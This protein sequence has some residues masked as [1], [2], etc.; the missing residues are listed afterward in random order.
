MSARREFTITCVR[1]DPDHGFWRA[2]VTNG[3]TLDVDR[4]HG[5]WQSD[6]RDAP[7]SRSFHRRDVLP[8][9]AAA[10]QA[11]VR[12]LEHAERAAA[13]AVKAAAEQAGAVAP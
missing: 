5:S 12:P 6:V 1:R 7:G 4:R 10:L 9:V 2:R 11:R 8:E 13:K 3:V